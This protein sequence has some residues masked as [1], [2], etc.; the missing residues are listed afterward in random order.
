M[1]LCSSCGHA[2]RDGHRFCSRCGAALSSAPPEGPQTSAFAVIGF[3]LAL[4][5]VCLNFVG[6]ILGAI[7]LVEISR[8]PESVRGRG[9]AIAAVVIGLGWV[10]LGV[11]AALG[12]PWYLDRR[13]HGF[14]EEPKRHLATLAASYRDATT[15]LGTPPSTFEELG[16]PL[17]PGRRYTYFI[18]DDVL[19]ADDGVAHELPATFPATEDAVLL[20]VGDVDSDHGLDIWAVNQAGEVRVY[21]DDTVEP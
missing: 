18:A 14:Q 1:I 12:V 2:T 8:K 19:E 5:P 11:G 10:V 15:R 20:A 6:V 13:A 9:L 7:A 17:P 3:V 16:T 21:L 4:I